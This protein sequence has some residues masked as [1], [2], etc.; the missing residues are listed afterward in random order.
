MK[1]K[2]KRCLKLLGLIFISATVSIVYGNY[3]LYYEIPE[4]TYEDMTI[5]PE[6]DNTG[7]IQAPESEMTADGKIN[8]NTASKEMLVVLDEIGDKTADKIIEYRTNNRFG[9]IEE[10]MNVQGIGE[11]TFDKIKDRI[12]VE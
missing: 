7:N 2:S 4:I 11:K 12:A 5:V 3:F 10:I 9:S 8:I 1:L 6:K